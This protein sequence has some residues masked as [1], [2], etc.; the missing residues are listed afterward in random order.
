LRHVKIESQTDEWAPDAALIRALNMQLMDVRATWG[1][2]S[3]KAIETTT[4]A[5]SI[6]FAVVDEI[7]EAPDALAYHDVD[8]HGRPYGRL[9]LHV[10]EQAGMSISSVLSHELVEMQG[11]LYC[12]EWSYSGRLRCLVAVELCDP[13]QSD[14]YTLGS[15]E[16]SNWVT[17]WYFIEEEHGRD[18]D[19]CRK[20]AESFSIAPGGYQ[21][22][23]HAGAVSNVF[24]REFPEPVYRAKEHARG[25][26]FWRAVTAALEATDIV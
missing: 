17:P 25:R 21:I 23:M 22:Q 15:V 10:C 12:Q 14:T 2:R 20:L 13:V 7:P 9:G 19:W 11:D 5:G 24:G 3:N 16:V 8:E 1:I 4:N 26:T 6:R 18:Y